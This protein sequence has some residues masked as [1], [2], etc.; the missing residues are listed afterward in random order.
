MNIKL[1]AKLHLCIER[2]NFIFRIGA[3]LG[4]SQ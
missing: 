4:L 1:L 3:R 2:Y